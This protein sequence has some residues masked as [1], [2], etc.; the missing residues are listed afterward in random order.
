MRY[1]FFT[2][3]PIGLGAM[4]WCVCVSVSLFVCLS[5]CLCESA[6]ACEAYVSV[7]VADRRPA[8]MGKTVRLSMAM[9]IIMCFSM[10]V[11]CLNLC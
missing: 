1:N 7:T 6:R 4:E 11:I 2:G 5:A 10:H 9:Q 8:L 3:S